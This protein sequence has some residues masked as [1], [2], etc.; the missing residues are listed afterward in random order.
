MCCAGFAGSRS[1]ALIATAWASMAHLGEQGYLVLTDKIM[2]VS[3][4]LTNRLVVDQELNST[5]V[6][7]QPVEENVPL[8]HWADALKVPLALK[9]YLWMN[10][11]MTCNSGIEGLD[12]R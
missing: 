10:M 7:L 4:S 5:I 8:P 1:G 12:A 9:G 6:S 3:C 11:S 2:M